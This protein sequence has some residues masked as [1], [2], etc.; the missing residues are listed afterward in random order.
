MSGPATLAMDAENRYLYCLD[1][2]TRVI[3]RIELATAEVTTVSGNLGPRAEIDSSWANSLYD[4]L[5]AGM[6]VTPDG[7]YIMSARGLRV[8]R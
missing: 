6:A 5:T 8:A 7:L 1:Y 4:G 3:R 2:A